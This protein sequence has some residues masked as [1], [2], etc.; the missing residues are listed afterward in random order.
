M[1]RLAAGRRTRQSVN[2][3]PPRN[4]AAAARTTPAA[5]PGAE[6]RASP[7]MP[8][9]KSVEIR[10][11]DDVLGRPVS[12]HMVDLSAGGIGLRLSRPL[13]RGREFV[14]V[15]PGGGAGAAS[16]H[17]NGLRY[18]VVRCLPQRDGTFLVGCSFIRVPLEAGREQAKRAPDADPGTDASA[19]SAA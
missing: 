11:L 2:P 9:D 8:V 15:L 12:A 6:R 13:A 7:R 3:T 17:P 18:R 1:A 16:A 19:A 4:P 14:L 5:E 10:P